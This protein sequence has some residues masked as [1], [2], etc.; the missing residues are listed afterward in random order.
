[1]ANGSRQATGLLLSVASM[2]VPGI[3]RVHAQTAPFA[4]A[5]QDANETALG[6]PG[7]LWVALGDSMSQGVGAKDITGGWVG[8]LHAQLAAAGTPLRLV[9]FSRTGARVRDVLDEQLPRLLA[10]P[11]QP[12]LVTILV[13]ANDMLFRKRRAAAV[14]DFARLLSRLPATGCVMA[15]LPRG[16][17]HA[18]AI[19]GLIERAAAADRL[20]IAEMRGRSWGSLVGTLADDHFHPNERGYAAIAAAFAA[21]IGQAPAS[22]GE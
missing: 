8:Q 19:N 15:T 6:E 7:P 11:D 2:L 3:G 5:W 10:L 4:K 1:M 18:L 16:N 9:N 21:A 14:P 22:R 20:R 12:V 17:Q 13:G